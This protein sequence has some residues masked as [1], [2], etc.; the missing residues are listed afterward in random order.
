MSQP[1][2]K[3]AKILVKDTFFKEQMADHNSLDMELTGRIVRSSM[4]NVDQ[5]KYHEQ[6]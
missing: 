1:K 6:W 2:A 3:A 5:D 4:E